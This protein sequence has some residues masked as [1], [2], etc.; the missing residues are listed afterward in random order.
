MLLVN[1]LLCLIC[2]DLR[3]EVVY[4]THNKNSNLSK[5]KKMDI[6][7]LKPSCSGLISFLKS[8]SILVIY[9]SKA[10]PISLLNFGTSYMLSFS[11]IVKDSLLLYNCS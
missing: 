5:N 6:T 11:W 9:R 1:I 4:M 10:Q 3:I 2:L 7:Q 8:T